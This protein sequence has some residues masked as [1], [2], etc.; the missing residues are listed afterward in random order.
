MATH[1]ER[2]RLSAVDALDWPEQGGD[3]CLDDIAALTADMFGAPVAIVSLTGAEHQRAVATFGAAQVGMSAPREQTFCKYVVAAGEIVVFEDAA[4]DAR[5]ANNPFVDRPAG[6]RFYAGAPLCAEEGHILG[7]LCLIDT[8]PR[9]FGEARRVQLK[10]L[11]NMAER[12]LQGR[13]FQNK[14]ARATE[15]RNAAEARTRA[16][17]HT[18][19]NPR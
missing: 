14:L 1:A 19:S 17:L 13:T 12:R 11:A 7:T 15:A 10:R 9:M 6:V 4:D 18:L 16:V 8:K 5:V 3:P 2:A